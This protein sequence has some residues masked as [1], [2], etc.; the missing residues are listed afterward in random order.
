VLARDR[1]DFEETAR[2]L[3]PQLGE[4]PRVSG[5]LRFHQSG[6]DWQQA[7]RALPHAKRRKS[8]ANP[9]LE[10]VK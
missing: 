4:R 2:F 6:C 3:I 7:K 9:F 10:Q 8:L 5:N 1:M